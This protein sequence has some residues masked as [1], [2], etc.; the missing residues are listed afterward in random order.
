MQ[1]PKQTHINFHHIIWIG[2]GVQNQLP[3]TLYNQDEKYVSKGCTSFEF[4]TECDATDKC[5]YNEDIWQVK[6]YIFDFWKVHTYVKVRN[7]ISTSLQG[8][9]V[10]NLLFASGDGKLIRNG[11]ILIFLV[12]LFYAPHSVI[13]CYKHKNM[14]YNMFLCL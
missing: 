8:F 1:C 5:P 10:Y 9:L 4:L 13:T 6:C 2:F 11:H 7:I 14:F 3:H 12:Y